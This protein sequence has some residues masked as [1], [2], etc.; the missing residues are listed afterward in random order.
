MREQ[1]EQDAQK[2]REQAGSRTR[3]DKK[4]ILGPAT[5]GPVVFNEP[6][7]INGDLNISSD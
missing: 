5:V 2:I 3:Q 4:I 7:T 1:A 6:V